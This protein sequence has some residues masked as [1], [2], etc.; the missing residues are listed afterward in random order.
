MMNLAYRWCIKGLRA[1]ATRARPSARTPSDA[2][3]PAVTS[4]PLGLDGQVD[5]LRAILKE[6]R[7]TL[8]AFETSR[9]SAARQLAAA[10]YALLHVRRVCGGLLPPQLA[11]VGVT[12]SPYASPAARVNQPIAA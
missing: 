2:N 6:T 3:V 1:A 10:D 7:G 11:V 9:T 12:R 5:R 4:G 8:D